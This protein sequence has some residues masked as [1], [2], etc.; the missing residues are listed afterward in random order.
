M[1]SVNFFLLSPCSLKYIRCHIP[2]SVTIKP[3]QKVLYYRKVLQIRLIFL[4]DPVLLLLVVSFLLSTVSSITLNFFHNHSLTSF[5]TRRFYPCLLGFHSTD[6]I[7]NTS[8]KSLTITLSDPIQET[9]TPTPFYTYFSYLL[10]FGFLP[11]RCHV[12]KGS[13][14]VPVIPYVT[15]FIPLHHSVYQVSGCSEYLPPTCLLPYSYQTLMLFLPGDRGRQYEGVK[16]H[17]ISFITED[18]IGSNLNS[19]CHFGF[20]SPFK[21]LFPLKDILAQ[22]LPGSLP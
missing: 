5:T 10:F 12:F 18:P 20:L 17:R 2:M 1:V 11:L 16:L 4:Y 14:T 19:F 8:Q 13:Y 3:C 6:S 7:L 21:L 9:Y 22:G 15:Q